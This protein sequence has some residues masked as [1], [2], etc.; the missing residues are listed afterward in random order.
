MARQ[1]RRT[2]DVFQAVAVKEVLK[3][4]A[5]VA[6]KNTFSSA[7]SRQPTTITIQAAQSAAAANMSGKYARTG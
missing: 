7:V 6:D 4:G 3:T 1:R 2:G 5:I